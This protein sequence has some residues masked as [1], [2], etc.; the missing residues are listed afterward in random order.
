MPDHF[1]MHSFRVGG[2]LSKSF[3]GTAVDEMKIGGWKTARVSRYYIG[4]IT[5]ASAEAAKGRR[6]GDSRRERDNSYAI[7]MDFPLLPA[8]QEDF[9]VCRP[10]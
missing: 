1:T 5:S 8:F 10:R 6:D 7:A 3:A 2:S 4:A 9:A